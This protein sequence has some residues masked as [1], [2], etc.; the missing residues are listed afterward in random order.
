[1]ILKIRDS[2]NNYAKKQYYDLK[3]VEGGKKANLSE[4][5]SITLRK[6]LKHLNYK[7]DG[8]IR[9]EIT[10]GFDG[11]GSY[12]EFGLTNNPDMKNQIFGKSYYSVPNLKS[13]FQ[14]TSFQVVFN[15]L[16]TFH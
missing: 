8:N 7:G 2:L 9:A 15:L 6:R 3:D 11:A 4:I 13:L 1:M 10:L 12:Q 14:R 16:F 5:L